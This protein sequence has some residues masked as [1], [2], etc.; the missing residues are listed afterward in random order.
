MSRGQILLVDDEPQIR[1]ILSKILGK[2]DCQVD[3]VPSGEEALQ[4]I[5][6]KRYH[7]VLLDLRLPGISGIEV[8]KDIKAHYPGT[9][10][11]VITAYGSVDN[12]IQAMKLGADDFLQKPFDSEHLRLIVSQALERSQAY[13]KEPAE[14][15][16]E[17]LELEL[18]GS[19]KQIQELKNMIE[20]VAR[21][22]STVL[23][24]GE[25]GTG[26]ELVAR[27]IHELSERREAPFVVVNCAAVPSTLLESQF[28]GHIK[29][30][31]TDAIESRPGY[32]E[33]AN[34]GTIFLDE[35]GELD[36][37]LQAKILRVLQEEEVIPVGS[38]KPISIDVRVIAA[39]NRNL[40]K[41]VEERR[42]RQDLYYRLSVLPIYVPPLR[43]HKEDLPL[44]I[45]H[46]LG[47]LRR[48]TEH[49][50]VG[51]SPEYLEI[52][53]NYDFP[54]N[55]R[56]LENII[57]HSVLL[58]T[59]PILTPDTL[60]QE[61]IESAEI[62]EITRKALEQGLNLKRA[63]ALATEKAE[64]RLIKRVLEECAGNFSLAARKLGIS[65]SA[66]YY[67]VKKYKIV[68]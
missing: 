3:A 21:V 67:K 31:F 30:A 64:S 58:A 35:I 19:S 59:G 57:E 42:F 52:L 28:F 10:V 51:V 50:V 65:R 53:K 17:E 55:V 14:Q 56:E 9:S 66:L 5:S 34:R 61:V 2:L 4:L 1:R 24:T 32:F 33:E 8:L 11:V 12:A 37:N 46:I 62:S 40:R 45:N 16:H 29:G 44:L 49:R 26:K 63:K 48:T 6:R 47:K 68:I 15:F 20:R 23:I 36:F 54:G 60:P 41:M 18:V 27:L 39:T 22:K 7:L 13:G 25:T 43:E 38:T